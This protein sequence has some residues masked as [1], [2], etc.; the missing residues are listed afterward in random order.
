VDQDY[1]GVDKTYYRPTDRGYE[2]EIK[3]WMASL[4]QP[5]AA[6]DANDEHQSGSDR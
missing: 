3:A 2:A 5:P 6:A 1:L 4:R